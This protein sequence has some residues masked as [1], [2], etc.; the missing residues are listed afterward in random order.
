MTF[1]ILMEQPRDAA[2]Y[3]HESSATYYLYVPDEYTG[4][5]EWPLFVG[6]HGGGGSGLDCWNLWQ[7][8]ADKE[9]F[10]LLCPSIPG[11]AGGF[12][13][14]VGE[15]VVKLAV[16]DVQ[17]DYRVKPKMFFAGFSAG[18]IFIQGFAY[19]YPNSVSGLAI[20]STGYSITDLNTRVPMILVTGNIES[21]SAIQANEIFYKA[22]KNKGIDIQY[23]VLPWVGHRVTNKAKQ[24]TIEL[25]RKTVG[26]Q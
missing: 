18:A 3:L 21:P 5:Y 12:Y 15:V 26:K 8:Y 7:P 13:L 22:M 11:D 17:K 6:I 19:H 4:D 16:E 1:K 20:L 24:L 23:H 14:D 25:F 10:I 2:P 9:H